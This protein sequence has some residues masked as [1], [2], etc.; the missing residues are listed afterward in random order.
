MDSKGLPLAEFEAEPQPFLPC[1]AHRL[2]LPRGKPTHR[3][4][5]AFL[6]PS[7]H[8][9]HPEWIAAIPPDRLRTATRASPASR[10]IAASVSW[11]GKVR[12][13]SAR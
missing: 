11:S 13:L 2:P 9:R 10:I 4:P 12:M 5:P 7:G 8:S 1:P 3:Q 6:A